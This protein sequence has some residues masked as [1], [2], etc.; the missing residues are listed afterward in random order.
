MEVYG[1]VIEYL[2]AVRTFHDQ[3]LKNLMNRR[4]N[5]F[6]IRKMEYTYGG[7]LIVSEKWSQF[8]FVHSLHVQNNNYPFHF[9]D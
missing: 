2:C 4:V 3:S 6:F 9:I 5:F 7:I 1:V 8:L